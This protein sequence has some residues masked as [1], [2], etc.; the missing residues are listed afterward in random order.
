MAGIGLVDQLLAPGSLIASLQ[1]S[2]GEVL[3]PLFLLLLPLYL[4][5]LLLYLLLY[6]C[7][8]CFYHCI[9]CFTTVF[10]A[11]TAAFAACTTVFTTNC[12]YSLHLEVSLPPS[13]AL[14][15]RP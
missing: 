7:I 13:D 12:L 15:P 14:D 6:H 5:L 3:L 2:A 10:T 8:Y 9:Y 4:L 1:G 11:F